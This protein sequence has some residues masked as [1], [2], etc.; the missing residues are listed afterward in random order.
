MHLLCPHCQNPIEIV[1][2]GSRDEILCPACGSSFRITGGSTTVHT[3]RE[4]LKQL[5]KF[6]LLERVGVGT[7]GT[8]YRARDLELER[9][10]AVKIPRP[11]SVDGDKDRE[12]FLREA[13]SVAR[14]RH[15]S[16]VPVY[17]IGQAEGVPFLVSD[18]VKG[19]TLDDFLTGQRLTFNDA[20]QLLATIAEALQVAHDEGVVHRDVKPSNIMLAENG[21]P[22]LMDFGLAKRD[23][24]EVTM[25]L[26][27]QVLGT[28]AYMSPEQARGESHAV[29]GR[30]DVYSL[31]VIL[32]RL[33]TGELPF[34]GNTR[35]LLHQV[36]N[37]EPKAPRG[38]NDKIPRDLETI[39]LKAMAKEPGRRYQT[40]GALADD[41]RRYLQ[42]Q[43]I[44]ARPVGRLQRGWRWARRNP[45]IAGLSAAAVL[46]LLAT[47]I[48]VS[49]AYVQ[50]SGARRDAEIQEKL[51]RA[52]EQQALVAKEAEATARTQLKK[53]HQQA[54]DHL[55][56]SLLHQAQAL[57]QSSEVDRRSRILAALTR[58]APIKAGEDLRDEA[59]RALDLPDLRPV[60]QAHFAAPA[61]SIAFRP[62]QNRILVRPAAG[63]PYELDA[64]SGQRVRELPDMQVKET[65]DSFKPSDPFVISPNGRLL[66]ELIP[67]GKGAQVWDLEAQKLLGILRD[68][69]GTPIVP[70]II[71]FSDRS[72]LLAAIAWPDGSRRYP[73]YLF[74][75]PSLKAV[76]HWQVPALHVEGLKLNGHWL[77]I[78]CI[79]ENLSQSLRL[80]DAG[81]G[82]E[83]AAMDLGRRWAS[84]PAHPGVDR[85]DI[86]ADGRLLAVAL[87]NG[88]VRIWNL[89]PGV[90]WKL[91]GPD[92]S[93]ALPAHLVRSSWFF[94]PALQFSPD[95]RWLATVG[96][97][98][99]LKV[100]D[101]DGGAPAAQARISSGGSRSCLSWSASGALLFFS[102][103]QAANT[104][105]F[106]PPHSRTFAQE[107]RLSDP[108]A[109]RFSDDERW[110]ACDAGTVAL[111]DL[112]HPE[113]RQPVLK[114]TPDSARWLRL[115][116]DEP[117]S[118][119]FSAAG[120]RLWR[121]SE[122][123]RSGELW[124]LPVP[125][126]HHRSDPTL[127]VV[128]T[129]F[130]SADQRLAAG[131]AKG[132][133]VHLI[134]VASGKELWNHAEQAKPAALPG[135]FAL[136]SDGKTL[137]LGLETPQGHKLQV[138]DGDKG[139]LLFERSDTRGRVFFQAERLMELVSLDSARE[140]Q[141]GP[142]PAASG[143]V[144][145]SPFT[146]ADVSFL[147]TETGTLCLESRADSLT[148]WDLDSKSKRVTLKRSSTA[149]RP[150]I[151]DPVAA[152]SGDGAYLAARDGA[153][154]AV[155]NTH[156]GE[157]VCRLPTPPMTMTFVASGPQRGKLLFADHAGV[158]YT[159][160]GGAQ[161]ATR[162]CTL[163]KAKQE[164]KN[165]TSVALP[166]LLTSDSARLVRVAQNHWQ[167]GQLLVWEIPSGKLTTSSLPLAGLLS[168][169]ALS[170][171][172]TRLALISEHVTPRVWNADSGQVL[173][174][175]EKTQRRALHRQ[176][177]QLSTDA[178]FAVRVTGE[179][180]KTLK[181]YDLT[182]GAE[183][184]ST[185][186]PAA[187]ACIAPA[188]RGRLVAAATREGILVYDPRSGQLVARCTGHEGEVGDLAF[189]GAGQ[190]L[191]SCSAVDRT[192]RLWNPRTGEQLVALH[193]NQK[194]FKHIALSRSGRWL[195]AVDFEGA[196]RLW[197][198]AE[199]RQNLRAL[200]LDWS[201]APIR[202][203]PVPAP[204]SAAA[205]LEQAWHEH[206]LEHYVEA[207]AAYTRALAIDDKQAAAYRDRGE[208]QFQLQRYAEAIADFERARELA[209][210][211]PYGSSY[212]PA[213]Q[214]RGMQEAE[215]GHW[216]KARADFLQAI[217]HGAEKDRNVSERALLRLA[218]GDVAGYRKACDSL[219]MNLVEKQDP[220]F[221]QPVV[222]TCLLAPGTFAD[223]KRLQEL[224]EDAVDG[225]PRNW[226][227][228]FTLGSVLYRAGD[229][230]GALQRLKHAFELKG[231]D[232]DRRLFL[233]MA[234][235]YQKLG[236][237]AEARAWFERAR[238][239]LEQ[240][241]ATTEPGK[242]LTSRLELMLLTRE[243]ESMIGGMRADSR[244]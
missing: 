113:L 166:W 217:K 215:R 214:C 224:A 220:A 24:G 77:A 66:A 37:E 112:H 136:R 68:A 200:G 183:A 125:V 79:E 158:V 184:F 231:D 34:R 101:T 157:E 152:L 190:V 178:S 212:A 171:D 195:A 58:A 30:G 202:S 18:F 210:D 48:T 46:L 150:G 40:A 86:S 17:E 42:G 25:T 133:T 151:H 235:A 45:M 31:G 211:V 81:S 50:V 61:D 60:S 228:H 16:I 7:F 243:A 198:L 199:V 242:S 100:W 8:V 185:E 213:L 134:D 205:V 145:T 131:A 115:T 153:F 114:G 239:P 88:T 13:R 90:G 32:Y 141:K 69:A 179:A 203:A 170:A 23:A 164:G 74:E 180:E 209:P 229:Q 2:L 234:M 43:P 109:L 67:S 21:K 44:Q 139:K 144:P 76:R 160:Q 206:L 208:A 56:E 177:F 173:L 36:M 107:S 218:A 175:L 97:D 189:D 223:Y 187:A 20:A 128:S 98:G 33:L 238:R 59:L 237:G 176:N 149:A 233:F 241:R 63:V 22:Q 204:G 162:I 123:G 28:P 226:L 62:V 4:E 230:D 227:Y 35:M 219:V 54:Q 11:G 169:L 38:L 52:G 75:L 197:D 47:L 72:D 140:V 129:A 165:I 155:W 181:V 116:R 26:D 130:N 236:R 14:L 94:P 78:T 121:E 1:E 232:G 135:Q 127:H 182:A 143:G 19:V 148:L 73:V 92:E 174:G 225:A 10:V 49:V 168:R 57:R 193:T 154:L 161:A 82:T 12:R 103:D 188:E 64:S 146:T 120:D 84:M 194:R 124:Q 163:E 110:L 104:W 147:P 71:A 119:A 106:V 102:A 167:T 192:I 6:E 222:W 3:P 240:A 80:W 196:G 159:W 216:D 87:A 96:G 221:T 39:C 41:L 15:P 5:G 27:G 201:A 108:R 138:W 99:W 65:R 156:T 85:I 93:F 9:I 191:A 29:D 122:T 244:K 142:A 55:R 126:G 137:A 186:M 95:G 105:Q 207:A 89:G 111:V 70:L 83:L 132:T 118:L 117:A 91:L 172:G 51:A 53:E